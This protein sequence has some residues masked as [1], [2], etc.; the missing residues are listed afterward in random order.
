[1]EII[2]KKICLETARSR[3]Q[4]LLAYIKY[5]ELL[6]AVT[7]VKYV[8]VCKMDPTT[9]E[10]CPEIV[11]MGNTKIGE[12]EF[13]YVTMSDKDGNYGNFV[14]NPYISGGTGAEL[15]GVGYVNYMDIIYRY[16]KIHNLL[17]D[18]LKLKR[19]YINNDIFYITD[20]DDRINLY[21][22]NLV[23]GS[24]LI[25]VSK[26]RYKADDE[27]LV[28]DTVKELDNCG[29]ERE[30]KKA[31][32]KKIDVDFGAF[33]N[34]IADYDY[35][36]SL[37]QFFGGIENIYKFLHFVEDNFIG[38][39]P[40][41]AE[42]TGD[43]V[44]EFL[45]YSDIVE[46][47]E[48]FKTYEGDPNCCIRETWRKKGGDAMYAFLASHLNLYATSLEN[49]KIFFVEDPEG[50]HIP[51][52]NI[53]LAI[54]SKYDDVGIVTGYIEDGED[55]EHCKEIDPKEETKYSC[56]REEECWKQ[57]EGVT[58]TGGTANSRILDLK[59]PILSYDDAGTVL[60]GI[61]I[62]LSGNGLFY[63]CEDGGR[64]WRKKNTYKTG[65]WSNYARLTIPPIFLSEGGYGK[66]SYTINI[67]EHPELKYCEIDRI[68]IAYEPKLGIP[69]ASI[70]KNDGTLNED[71]YVIGQS[72][73]RYYDEDGV[74]Y[75]NVREL[76]GKICVE[77]I[78]DY[79]TNIE[80]SHD[81]DRIKFEYTIQGHYWASVK[82]AHSSINEQIDWHAYAF[83]KEI[84]GSGIRYTEEYDYYPN[85]EVGPYMFYRPEQRKC[86]DPSINTRPIGLGELEERMLLMDKIDFDAAKVRI[87]HRELEIERDGLL[88]TIAG[89]TAGDV[90]RDGRFIISGI[91]YNSKSI[92]KDVG[93]TTLSDEKI[94][95]LV[96][97]IYVS[98]RESIKTPIYKEEALNGIKADVNKKINFSVNRGYVS[99]KEMHYKLS[100][101]N[102]LEDL[103]NYGNNY[104][105]L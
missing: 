6:S 81:R 56:K 87:R 1:M 86:D 61:L 19:I 93:I 45:Y 17:F 59:S 32:K 36:V 104:F 34:C 68:H 38:I 73:A 71:G 80:I 42:I 14:C 58:I 24:D 78:G 57:E 43:S 11:P 27:T 83:E 82:R 79:I 67:E 41:P 16:N 92:L 40:I 62:S 8:E 12:S 5:S 9:G 60:P 96:K 49:A 53:G 26:G 76:N 99:A 23:N 50:R 91:P 20:F 85:T 15:F 70:Y 21:D 101:C 39:L 97:T 44:P 37:C 75:L 2:R 52:I 66:D 54:I 63:D 7:S 102:S 65:S 10:V 74:T 35:L 30:I 3:Q 31:T 100:E 55:Y 90:W 29:V 88:A 48:W 105:N 4:G 72:Y 25:E 46:W 77:M 13:S 47:Y 84:E 51:K 98:S 18:G 28:Y 33:V 94:N 89:Y 95:S 69:F 22:Y 64:T 103:E